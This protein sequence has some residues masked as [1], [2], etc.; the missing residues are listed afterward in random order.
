MLKILS[1]HNNRQILLILLILICIRCL[2]YHE[3]CC[4]NFSNVL[5]V[6]GA[7][8]RYAEALDERESLVIMRKAGRSSLSST[9][10]ATEGIALRSKSEPYIKEACIICQKVGGNASK[11]AYDSTSKTMLGASKK[12]GDKGFFRR[13]NHI[14]S[15]GDGT[16]N[17]VVYHNNCWARVRS[18]IHPRKKKNDNVAH[19]LSEFEVINFV[20]TQI[21][22]PEQSCL[23]INMV[24]CM[25][26]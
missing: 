2:R 21:N 15:V 7:K 13:L 23:D 1:T 3:K 20:Q 5:Q 8:K 17:D 14:T 19:T 22:D 24:D 11:V 9:Q 25:F 16:A 10:I 4:K 6:E 18:K 12:L 26:K